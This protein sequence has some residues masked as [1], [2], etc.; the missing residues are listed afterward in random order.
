MD[1]HVTFDF[2]YFPHWFQAHLLFFFS[3]LDLFSVGHELLF[4]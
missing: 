2:S 1:S 4:P 3:S